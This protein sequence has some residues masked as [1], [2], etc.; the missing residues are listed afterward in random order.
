MPV[1]VAIMELAPWLPNLLP[2]LADDAKLDG[3][4]EYQSE[5]SIKCEKSL[6]N[7][8]SHNAKRVTKLHN[9][10]KISQSNWDVLTS[11]I[12]A[13]LRTFDPPDQKRNHALD[14]INSMATVIVEKH[15]PR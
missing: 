14:F 11:S 2:C 15:Q 3:F 6:I 12:K 13:I 5:A 1:S 9:G 10:I 8:H 4:W 7:F